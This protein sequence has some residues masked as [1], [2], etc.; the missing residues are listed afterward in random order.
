MS[1]AKA[2]LAWENRVELIVE[3]SETKR[4]R[5]PGRLEASPLARG[6]LSNSIL[7]GFLPG[8]FIGGEQGKS[9]PCV[10]ESS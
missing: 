4:D 1:K 9:L 3:R 6:L 7:A 2:C 5:R 10:G 8:F